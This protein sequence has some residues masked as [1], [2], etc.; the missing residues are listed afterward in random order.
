MKK[1]KTHI[2][3]TITIT[4]LTIIFLMSIGTIVVFR[5]GRVVFETAWRLDQISGQIEFLQEKPSS[6]RWKYN[7]DEEIR[8]LDNERETKYYQSENQFVK[9]FS[10]L[11]TEGKLI[12]YAIILLTA[13][14][15]IATAYVWIDIARTVLKRMF[16]KKE[17]KHQRR[18]ASA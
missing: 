17:R 12:Q 13:V 10:N 8:S 3:I 11:G 18:R 16:K 9:W 2:T 14:V 7:Y 5:A 6:E 1:T 15:W 4:L